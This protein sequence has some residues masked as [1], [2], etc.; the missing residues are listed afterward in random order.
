MALLEPRCLVERVRIGVSAF[1][2]I[3]IGLGVWSC[4]NYDIL[5]GPIKTSKH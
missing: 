4:G 1:R 3:A 2:F 5:G